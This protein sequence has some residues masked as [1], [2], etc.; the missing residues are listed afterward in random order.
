MEVVG[1]REAR[2]GKV[3]EKIPQVQIRKVLRSGSIAVFE[4]ADPCPILQLG[5]SKPHAGEVTSTEFVD[6]A[7]SKFA[8]RN[9]SATPGQF[10]GSLRRMRSQSPPRPDSSVELQLTRQ[11]P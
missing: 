2:I 8:L 1:I 3:R 5:N 10:Q 6:D 11:I 9:S 4:P 7:L